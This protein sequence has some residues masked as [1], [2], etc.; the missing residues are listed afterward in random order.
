ILLSPSISLINY[1]SFNLYYLIII[2]VYV[3]VDIL[4]P[5]LLSNPHY[6]NIKSEDLPTINSTILV[7]DMGIKI[8]LAPFYGIFCDKIGR[9]FVAFIGLTSMC[10]GVGTLP[11]M[12]YFGRG[13]VFPYFIFARA[14]YANGAIACI[15]V[16]LLADYV[17]YE[18]KGRAAGLLVV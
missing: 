14:I 6:Y 5:I 15:V 11:L 1:I 4:Q 17:D 16:P 13:A 3:S 2:F 7:W 12:G 10:I 8:L 9:K 18:T